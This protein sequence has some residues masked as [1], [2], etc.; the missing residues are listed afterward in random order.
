MLSWD[1]LSLKSNDSTKEETLINNEKID[2][3]N[4][5]SNWPCQTDLTWEINQKKQEII[6]KK[7]PI[8]WWKGQS[9]VRKFDNMG[10]ITR[11]Y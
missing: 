4:T 1:I 9:F 11:V 10:N 6:V 7:M 8:V 5:S 3:R 2:Y